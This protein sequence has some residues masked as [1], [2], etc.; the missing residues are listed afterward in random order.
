MSDES[1]LDSSRSSGIHSSSDEDNY[2]HP[3]AP[4]N[5]DASK[6]HYQKYIKYLQ[7]QQ[8]KLEWRNTTLNESNN[9]LNAQQLKCSCKRPLKATS[10]NMISSASQPSSAGLSAAPSESTASDSS[11]LNDIEKLILSSAKK[12]TITTAMFL[13]D[14]AVFQTKCPDPPTDISNPNHYAKKSTKRDALVT[15]LYTSIDFVLHPRM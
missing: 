9:V 7:L 13:P 8:G 1:D 11:K 4:P 5:E 3:V 14:K 6:E 2:D 10:S 15:E 12:Y